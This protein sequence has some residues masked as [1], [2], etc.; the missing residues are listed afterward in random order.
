MSGR[1]IF[2]G[3]V[4]V[5]LEKHARKVG[6]VKL[7]V[8]LVVELEEGGAVRVVLLQVDVVQLRLLRREAAVLA[9]VHLEINYFSLKNIFNRSRY[10]FL[11]SVN[12][13]K[14]LAQL[15][16]AELGTWIGLK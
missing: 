12:L 16:N 2:L 10:S 4:L 1:I 14:K 7:E 8:S 15:C 13:E 3:P 11:E 5:D 9:D 6:V